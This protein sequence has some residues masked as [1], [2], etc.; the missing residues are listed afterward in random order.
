MAISESIVNNLRKPKLT[1]IGALVDG[2]RDFLD[3]A[4]EPFGSL[5][6]FIT[7]IR[8]NRLAKSNNFAVVIGM[9]KVLENPL[10]G[11]GVSKQLHFQCEDIELGGKALATEPHRTKGA[12]REMPYDNIYAPVNMTFRCS[13]DAG[14]YQFFD[15]WQSHTVNENT[16]RVTYFDNIKAIVRLSILDGKK[17]EVYY[18]KLLEAYPKSITPIAMSHGETD[19]VAK[20]SVEWAYTKYRPLRDELKFEKV[21][22]FNAEYFTTDKRIETSV[23]GGLAGLLGGGIPSFTG[24]ALNFYNKLDEISTKYTGVS[25]SDT[26]NVIKEV[27]TDIDDSEILDNGEKTGLLAVAS[28]LLGGL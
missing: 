10:Q 28:A 9:P 14:E 3:G 11:Q 12:P 16:Y 20:F 23:S 5:T 8:N 4:D 13:E 17:N 21:D 7:F 27:Q 22:P 18:V 19:T 26:Q 6:E 15:L 1:D 24:E 25:I 2:V